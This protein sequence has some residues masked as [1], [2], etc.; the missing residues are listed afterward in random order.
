MFLKRLK[1]SERGSITIFVLSTMLLVVGVVFVSY[2]SMMNKSS[3]QAIEL[4]KIQE[5]Y[6][7]SD[8]AMA[9]IYEESK[10]VG[11]GKIVEKNEEYTDINGDIA[12]IPAGFGI[13]ENKE[14]IA[15]GLVVQD[16]EGNEFVLFI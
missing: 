9:Q 15:D 12:T 8:S 10:S 2:F 14:I 3:S 7:Q 6:N 13:V 5:E 1:K 11:T 4:N 16:S